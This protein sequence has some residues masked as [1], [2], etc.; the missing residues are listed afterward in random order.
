M[1]ESQLEAPR[2]GLAPGMTK[3]AFVIKHIGWHIEWVT[4]WLR[5]AEDHSG[6]V[7]F[8]YYSEIVDPRALLSRVFERLGIDPPD[9]FSIAPTPQD[10]YREKATTDWRHELTPDAQGISV[11]GGAAMC[12][13]VIPAIEEEFA[14]PAF[15]NMSVEV[16]H[17]LVHPRIIP[18]VQGWGRLLAGG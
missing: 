17:N 14:K 9:E 18:P 1:R 11:P 4:E 8:S 3:S 10:R 6:L 5:F 2:Q 15:T 12:L 13:H 7:E 16:W